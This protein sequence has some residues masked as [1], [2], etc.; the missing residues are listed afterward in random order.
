MDRG[1]V[2][3]SSLVVLYRQICEAFARPIQGSMRSSSGV[4]LI[5]IACRSG[6]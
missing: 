6:R 3:A 1:L 5:G 4:L 2:A